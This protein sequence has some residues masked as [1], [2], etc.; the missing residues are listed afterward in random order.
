MTEHRNFLVGHQ[1]EPF[2]R[3]RTAVKIHPRIIRAHRN[4]R[5]LRF[6]HGEIIQ[7]VYVVRDL[8]YAVFIK[9]IAEHIIQQFV[10]AEQRSR[11]ASTEN[12]Q[13][14]VFRCH[15]ITAVPQ[16]RARRTERQPRVRSGSDGNNLLLFSRRFLIL[17]HGKAYPRRFVEK[18]IKILCRRI[19]VFVRRVFRNDDVI[20][21]FVAHDVFAVHHRAIIAYRTGSVVDIN[22]V[23]VFFAP[24]KAEREYNSANNSNDLFHHTTSV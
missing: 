5:F 1:P 14:A 8:V 21:F 19:D 17:F 23:I 12:I 10:Y 18:Q 6:I 16:F 2:R 24:G 11:R 4:R 22:A 7:I 9:L 20:A 3:H 15:P 13:A